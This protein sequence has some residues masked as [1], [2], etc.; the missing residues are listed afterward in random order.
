MSLLPFMHNLP[1]YFTMSQTSQIDIPTP[2]FCKII[3]TAVWRFDVWWKFEV[4]SAL[5]YHT[6][7]SVVMRKHGIITWKKCILIL[8]SHMAHFCRWSLPVRSFSKN[9]SFSSLPCY[10]LHPS[11][12]PWFAGTNNWWKVQFILL[13]IQK[14]GVF[15]DVTPCGSCKNRR[16]GGP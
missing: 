1:V 14:N 3:I 4:C 6:V 16:F 8:F 12:I 13:I 10:L 11:H 7:S 5:W 2:N 9:L 15:W